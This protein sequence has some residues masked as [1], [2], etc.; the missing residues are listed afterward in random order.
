[1]IREKFSSDHLVMYFC[2]CF[3]LGAFFSKGGYSAHAQP[4]KVVAF[5]GA[6]V[7]LPCSFKN[8]LSDQVPTVEWS[9]EG[10]TNSNVVFLYRDGC[11]TFEMKNVDFEFR[12]SL[13]MREVKNGNVSLRI[14]NVKLCDAGIYRCLIIQS[15]TKE[16]T[17]VE[18]VVAAESDPKLEVVSVENERVTVTCQ[19]TCVLPAPLILILDDKGNDITDEEPNQEQ[20][21]RGCN[22]TRQT[23]SMQ[24][25]TRRVVCRVKLPQTD[26]NKTAEILL[27]ASCTGFNV[28]TI[29]CTIGLIFAFCLLS[30]ICFYIWRKFGKNDRKQPCVG[31]KSSDSDLT[32]VSCEN[33]GLI[34]NRAENT[35]KGKI[36]NLENEVTVLRSAISRKYE[37][38]SKLQEQIQ[39]MGALYHHDRPTTAQHFAESLHGFSGCPNQTSDINIET[40]KIQSDRNPK[41]KASKHAKPIQ[42]NQNSNLSP[43]RVSK[44]TSGH[45]S[46]SQRKSL[47]ASGFAAGSDKK[48]NVDPVTDLL[49]NAGD[50]GGI[51]HRRQSSWPL[52]QHQ[53]NNRYFPLADLT[54]Q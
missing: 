31:R 26:Q 39:S 8:P 47:T 24:D 29:C 32:N 38:I 16:T 33:L 5:A 19:A 53:F 3:L 34:T 15:G 51:V 9:K 46:I 20:D 17:K 50:S 40:T 1:M 28:I 14:S 4:E 13:F 42:Q 2:L 37:D 49:S 11:E 35:G 25:S 41:K 18:L 10:L 54:E 22:T 23:F 44:R 52:T 12:T 36:N 45:S 43:R 6:H 27:L 30:G 48:R 21:R 7:I